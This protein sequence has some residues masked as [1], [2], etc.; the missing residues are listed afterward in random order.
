MRLRLITALACAA[1]LL[2]SG[3]AAATTYP[4]KQRVLVD[5]ALYAWGKLPKSTCE[6][7]QVGPNDR[8]GA[9]RYIAG[10]MQCLESTWEQHFSAS[11]AQF[12]EAKLKFAGGSY[13]ELEP[14]YDSDS[15]YCHPNHTVVY[16]LG[17]S[18]LTDP[19]DLWLMYNT[20][21]RYAQ[22]IQ[23]LVLIIH[24]VD[25]EAF[26]D[27]QAERFERLRRYRLQS[28]CLAGAFVKSVWPLEGRSAR[29][30]KYLQ[31]MLV[32][33][34]PG[35]PRAYGKTA[36]LKLWTKRGFATGDPGSC[37]TW[38]APASEVS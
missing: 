16:K 5:N 7:A 12:Q 28:N 21:T 24:S 20:A 37:N 34:V 38:K 1:N 4:V 10:V 23:E 26:Y 29:A 32:G 2:L 36:N 17:K 11:G 35:R 9:K 27:S 19:S 33:D 3:T 31:A 22:H 18:W 14:R 13:C 30:W 25:V 6:E 15:V 8:A